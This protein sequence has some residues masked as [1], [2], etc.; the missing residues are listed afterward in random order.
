MIAM[1][2]FRQRVICAAGALSAVL[3]AS[4]ARGAGGTLRGPLKGW[5][6]PGRG[7]LYDRSTVWQAINGAAEL[8]LAYGMRSFEQRE[9]R[10]GKGLRVTVQL[11]DMGA[12]LNAFG[13]FARERPAEANAVPTPGG[14]YNDAA[15]VGTVQCLAYRGARYLRAQ[16]IAG[17]LTAARCAALLAGLA[18]SLPGAA[19]VPEEL[20]WLPAPGQLAGSAGFA[21]KSCFGLRELERCVYA[22]YRGA[23][24]DK[25]HEAFVLLGVGERAGGAARA[26]SAL[27]GRWKRSQQG[28]LELLSRSVPYRGLV[29]VART[30]DR[31]RIYG[32]TGAADVKQAAARLAQVLVAAAAAKKR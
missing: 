1:R 29:A 21:L 23:A 24:G 30:P 15:L 16:A 10:Q 11:L 6:T 20:A 9:Y 22:R 12:P 26:W 17:E 3:F 27:A 4:A 18:R 14:A 8:Y 7:E 19:E 28:P 32:V 13:V 5:S 25:E 2:L 31:L